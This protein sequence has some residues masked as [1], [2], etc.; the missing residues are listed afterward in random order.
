MRLGLMLPSSNTVM[1]PELYEMLP[2][3]FSLHTTRLRIRK[4]T[5]RELA[6]MEK[7]IEQEAR[8]L[9]DAEVDVIGYGCTSGSLFRGLGHDR[10]IQERIEKA[11][12][13]P[14][15]ATSGA[16]IKALGALDIRKV[17][18]AT[19]YIDEINTLEQK[20]LSGNGLEVVDLQGLGIKD[21]IEIGKVSAQATGDLIKRLRSDEADGIFVS[22]TDLPTIEIIGTLEK[23][24][25]KPI[26][27]SN[28]ASLWAMLERC[29][30]SA[31]IQGFGKLLEG[32][33]QK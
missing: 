12:G 16:V 29:G 18:V 4:A 15:V 23:A 21:I 10:M 17:A 26:I 6:E 14:A 31:K 8:K 9:S 27:S 13:V 2:K 33:P 5:V 1:E 19:P 32:I 7:K 3:G 25:G 28:T 30:V 22:C 11:S 24:L 20:F